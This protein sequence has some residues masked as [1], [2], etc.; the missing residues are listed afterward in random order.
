MFVTGTSAQAVSRRRANRFA[1]PAILVCCPRGQTAIQ[2][3][4]YGWIG[5]VVHRLAEAGYSILAST[6][7]STTNWGNAAAA[8]AL[9]ALRSTA[10]STYGA[11]NG[12]VGILATSMGVLAGLRYAKASPADVAAFVGGVPAVD[13]RNIH[14]VT[15]TDLA[16]EIETAHGGAGGYSTYLTDEN[17][18]DHATT[19]SVLPMQLHRASNDSD[20]TASTVDAFG[21]TAGAEVISLGAVGHNPSSIDAD[22]VLTFFDAHL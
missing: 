15:R 17:P 4:Q 9:G 8:T 16:S 20:V 5:Q 6:L 11:A 19:W 3:H 22:A 7:G 21:A 10:I 14:D 1:R 2:H 12:P 13:L 18:A